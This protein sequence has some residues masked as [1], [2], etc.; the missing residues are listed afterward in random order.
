VCDPIPASTPDVEI[1]SEREFA[2]LCRLATRALDA[3]AAVVL[4]PSSSTLVARWGEVPAAETPGQLRSLACVISS[5][6]LLVADTSALPACSALAEHGIAAFLAVPL[7]GHSDAVLAVTSARPREWGGDDEADLAHISARS[8]GNLDRLVE[9]SPDIVARFDLN[10]RHSYVNSAVQRLTGLPPGAFLGRTHQDLAR[11]QGLPDSFVNLWTEALERVR[12]TGVEEEILSDFPGPGGNCV[13]SCHLAPERGTS[14]TVV[15]VLSIARDVT[16]LVSAQAAFRESEERFRLMVEGSGEIFFYVHDREH[17]FTYLSPSI[18]QVLGYDPDELLGHRYDDLLTGEGDDAGV[19]RLTE[20][21]FATRHRGQAYTTTVRHRDGRSIVLELVEG[22]LTDATGTLERIQGFARDVTHRREAETALRL[23]TAYLEQLFEGAPEAVVLL[24]NDSRIVRVNREFSRVFGFDPATV[25][26]RVIDE[27]IAPPEMVGE[28]R[29]IT[30]RVREG[31]TVSLDTVRLRSDRSPIHVSL[32]GTPI[33]LEGEQV[34]VYGIYRDIT[35]RKA[36]EAALRE[37]EAQFRGVVEGLGEGL[38]LTDLEGRVLYV[39]ERFAEITGFRREELHGRLAYQVLLQPDQW[40]ASRERTRSRAAGSSSVY[41]VE[42]TR[43]DGSRVW[44]EN[45]ASALRDAAGTVVGTIGAAADVTER[46]RAVAALRQ[47]E[48]LF[49][50]LIENSSDVIGI[51][52]PDGRIRYVTPSVERVL[53]F[54]PDELAGQSIFDALHPR[55]A[56]ALRPALGELVE[57]SDGLRTVEG[58][59]RHRD[60]SWRIFEVTARNLLEN[61]SVRGIVANSRDITDRKTAEVQLASAEAHYRRLVEASPYGI[62]VID[63]EHRLQEMNPALEAILGRRPAEV[64]GHSFLE[65]LAA[66]DRA[67][68]EEHLTRGGAG[69]DGA[70]EFELWVVRPSGERRLVL[71]RSTPVVDRAMEPG[72]QGVVRDVTEERTREDQFRRAERL[73]SLGTLV[74]GVAHELNNPLTSIKS[75]AQLLL[76]DARPVEDREALEIIQRE[77]E[78]SS[79]IVSDLRVVS[80]QTDAADG[81]FEPVDVNEVVRHV[82]RIRRYTLDTHNVEVEEEFSIPPPAIW[83]DRG[84]VEQVLLNLVVNA[85]QAMIS[86]QGHRRLVVRTY[87]Q[88]GSVL[89][90]VSD[91]GSGILPEHLE[92]IFDP[93]FTTRDPGEGTG[94]GLSLVHSIV[95]DHEGEIRVESV[96]GHGSSFT[97]RFPEAHRGLPRQEAVPDPAGATRPL[98]ILVVDDEEPIRRSLLRYLARRGHHVDGA[99]DGGEALHRLAEAPGERSYDVI[100]ADLRMPGLGGDDLLQ[101]LRDQRTGLDRRLIFMTG[102]AASPDSAR[103][104]SAA[105]VPVVLKPFELAEVA[106]IVEWH[107]DSD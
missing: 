58:R 2:R 21:T 19:H 107:V 6:T 68:A 93:F 52:E 100:L 32:L 55:D 106:Q 96:P 82:L 13:F 49:R 11:E 48:E 29:S 34:G 88:D 42:L 16:S 79:K 7:G 27:L 97:V 12:D 38:L 85:E 87:V 33:V 71:I 65:F 36:A 60:G 23:Q 103:I 80:R 102:D 17:R 95:S 83:A 76:L 5:G 1:G 67:T 90:Q 91:T 74:S 8:S 31:T 40:E 86:Q 89:L 43:K 37:S 15:S 94:L 59:V 39:N 56:A 72:A 22:P 64:L 45:H 28:A 20:D 63:G 105:G 51:L 104:L 54:V 9:S 24:D 73:A 78:R 35:D 66:E 3:E 62:Y 69:G 61:P 4:V 81:R 46:R 53:G 10:L 84:Q 14:G 30:R 70:W 101:K 75:F 50:S 99:A 98:R 41:E 18:R 26:G 92:R 25:T 44:V 57:S 47:S 77:A